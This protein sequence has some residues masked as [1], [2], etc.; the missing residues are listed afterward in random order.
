MTIFHRQGRQGPLSGLLLRTSVALVFAVG[1]ASVHAAD[2]FAFHHEN[3]L[4]TSLEIQVFTAELHTAQQ[5]ETRILQ[6]IER[7]AEIFSTYDSASEFSRWQQTRNQAMSLSPELFHVLSACEHY[8]TLSHGTFNPATQVLTDLWKQCERQQKVPSDIEL[9]QV[10]ARTQKP[11]WSLNPQTQQA[12]RLNEA[13]LTLNAIAKGTIIDA[14]T[15]AAMTGKD[16]NALSGVV[17]CIGGDLRVTGNITYRINIV[18]PSNPAENAKP[19]ATILIRNRSVATSG[20]YRRGF[21]INGRR[22]SHIF[23]PRTGQPADRIAS[24]AVVAPSAEQADALA[25]I[26]SILTPEESGQI[27]RSLVGVDYLLIDSLERRFSSPG[28]DRI[29]DASH[30]QLALFES[31]EQKADQSPAKQATDQKNAELLE[32]IVKFELNTHEKVQYRRPYVAVWLEDEKEFPVRTALLFLQTTYG[33]ARWHRDLLRWY[34]RDQLRRQTDRKDLIETISGATRGPGQ[35]QALFN[36][37][38]DHGQPLKP[39]KY[40]LYIESAREHGTCQLIKQPLELGE[41]PIAET[42]LKGNIEIKSASFEYRS[43]KS[44]FGGK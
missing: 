1:I 29:S 6:E 2:R 21:L 17:I 11:Q 36:G 23:D 42:P 35:Y 8:Q 4:G 41:K 32:L 15:Q 37:K 12:T 9:K 25:T 34:R 31:Q 20:N 7:L 24:A 10:I 5:A 3:V 39:G 38:D 19:A 30:E 18:A 14:A 13:T 28:W 43:P 40:T 44:N 26:F 33:G 16:S 22:Y 27:T